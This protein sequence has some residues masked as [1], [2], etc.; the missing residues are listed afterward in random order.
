MMEFTRRKYLMMMSRTKEE[1]EIA[2]PNMI[3]GGDP[4][5]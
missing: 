4:L 1:L 2:N 3:L 5:E